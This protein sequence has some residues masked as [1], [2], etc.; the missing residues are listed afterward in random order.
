M[1]MKA[2]NRL[3][4]FRVQGG[5]LLTGVCQL[6][7]Q[8]RR[9]IV[10]RSQMTSVGIACGMAVWLFSGDFLSQNADAETV[11]VGMAPLVNLDTTMAVRGERSEGVAKPVMLDVLG[12]TKAN[13]RVAVKAEVT[14]R[15][16]EVLVNRGAYVQAGEPLCRIAADSRVAELREAKAKQTSAEI[17][18]Q[19]GL[20]LSS[21]GMQSTIAMAKLAAQREQSVAR[22]DAATANLAKTELS[23]PFS[24]FVEE[25]SV[26]VGDLVT[27]GV[28][29]AVVIEL[30]P[31]LV[32]GQVAESEV[33][34]VSVGQSVG[35]SVG[36]AGSELVGQITFVAR[37][38]DPATRSFKVEARIEQPGR[39]A[40]AGLSATLSLPIREAMA[41][42]VSPASLSLDDSGQLGLKI[43]NVAGRV[44]FKTVEIVEEGPEGIWVTGLP[45]MATVITAGHEDVVNG[46]AVD[47]D[48][49]ELTLLSQN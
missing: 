23:A 39:A 37:T 8:L 27:P 40:R 25:R 31:L 3:I 6:A 36:A 30:E 15:V 21:R 4:N 1:R 24:G 14:G 2:A 34:N 38:P 7:K 43:A 35:V 10:N 47:V 32:V 16:T 29:C 26:E 18:Y 33:S 28:S 9:A 11:S 12:Q 42:L 44:E 41:H 17:A 5:L 22:V 48:F 19:G 13:R 49:S 45:Q 20:D 46:Q